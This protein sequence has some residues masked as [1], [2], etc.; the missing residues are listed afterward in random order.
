MNCTSV[1]SRTGLWATLV[2][3][4][5]HYLSTG[6]WSTLELDFG[7]LGDFL[8]FFL[9]HMAI[10]IV[11]VSW[12]KLWHSLVRVVFFMLAI[13]FTIGSQSKQVLDVNRI[14]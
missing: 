8:C 2:C 3:D 9:F 12:S 11:K 13:R 6:L 4:I 14:E 1:Y 7:L 10:L 5:L